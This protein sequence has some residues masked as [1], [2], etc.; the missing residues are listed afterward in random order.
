[1][2]LPFMLRVDAA[3]HESGIPFRITSGARCPA[4]NNAISST[5]FD[6]PHTHLC[7]LDIQARNSRERFLIRLALINQGFHRFGTAKTFLHVDDDETKDP[8]VEWFY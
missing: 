3:R 2:Q 7:A 8:K 6:G 4:H 5:G 1:M